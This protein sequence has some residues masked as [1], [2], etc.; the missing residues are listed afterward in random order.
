MGI[1]LGSGLQAVNTGFWPWTTAK[2]PL[3]RCC[4]EVCKKGFPSQ[5]SQPKC[6]PLLRPMGGITKQLAPGTLDSGL[7][8]DP[9]LWRQQLSLGGPAGAPKL[10]F[11]SP[12]HPNGAKMGGKIEVRISRNA[13][14]TEPTLLPTYYVLC[15][16]HICYSRN[17]SF[18]TII[19]F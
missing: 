11:G 1:L 12:G 14:L 19:A 3:R 13:L 16:K 7:E 10:S 8:F 15:F 17:C 2:L 18:S 9:F 4:Q 6:V 5:A